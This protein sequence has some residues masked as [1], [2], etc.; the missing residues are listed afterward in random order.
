[1]NRRQIFA[2]VPPM[3]K[4]T[5]SDTPQSPPKKAAPIAPPAGPDSISRTGNSVAVSTV[6][7][8]PEDSIM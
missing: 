8:P 3:S 2:V 4:A 6:A 7:M 1:M 5:S